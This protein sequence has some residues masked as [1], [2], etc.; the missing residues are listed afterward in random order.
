MKSACWDVA[1][2]S[3]PFATL[4]YELPDCFPTSFWHAGLVVVVP[5]GK[6]Y[7]IGVLLGPSRVE[8]SG[9]RVR[10]VLWPACSRDCL[11]EKYMALLQDLAL[12]QSQLP[13]RVLANVLPRFLKDAKPVFLDRHAGTQLTISALAHL[14]ASARKGLADKW[15]AGTMIRKYAA[16]RAEKYCYVVQ[17]PPWPIRPNAMRQW[18]ILHYL[19]ENRGASWSQVRKHVPG[20]STKIL[21]SLAAKGLVGV[22]SAPYEPEPPPPRACTDAFPLSSEQQQGLETLTRL[23]HKPAPATCLVHGVTG[24]GKTRVYLEL[25]R[26]CLE[27]GQ[28]VL[29]LAPEVAIALQLFAEAKGFFPDGEVLLYHGYQAAQTREATFARMAE[30]AAPLLVVGTRSALFLPGPDPGLIILDEEHD[31]SFKQD[32]RLVYHAKEVGYYRVQRSNGL[33][34][35]GSATPDMKTFYAAREEDIG[36]VSMTSRIGRTTLPEI[37]LVDL[38][39]FPAHAGPFAAPCLE[40]LNKALAAGDQIIIMHNRRGY[41]PVLYCEDCGEPAQCSHCKISLTYHKDVNRMVCHYCGFTRPFPMICDHCGG[42]IF[43]PV[44]AGTEK[45]EE[46]LIKSLPQ[47][48]GIARLDRD[49]S[50]RQGQMEQILEAF[51]KGQQQVLVGTQM[52]SKGHHFPGVTLVVV[53]DGDLGLNLPDYRA[54]ERTFQLLVQVAGRAGRGEKPGKVLIQTRNPEHHCWGFIKNNDYTGFFDQEIQLRKRFGYPPF[55]KLGLLRVSYPLEWKEG[56]DRLQEVSEVIRN[57]ASRLGLRVLGPAP[58]PL[59][60]L[61]GRL[62]FQCLIKAANWP[63]IRQ[64]FA[65]VDHHFGRD[66]HLRFTYDLDPLNML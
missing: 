56:S 19:W 28:R 22:R 20:V 17:D 11:D 53:V 59:Q 9:F 4:T 23:L 8:P 44:G 45:L 7:R 43:Q 14:D 65:A 5:M 54:T 2:I 10:T 6:G 15:L 39:A 31:G 55:V 36:V 24:S 35:L 30:D 25:A 52:L 3:A 33:L 48:T 66:R 37:R 21:E 51:A 42:S 34:V 13:G 50:R 29:L 40:E 58:A 38:K 18:D 46:F 47:G 41:A 26:V 63:A 57:Q 27:R 1:I 61:R 62:R 64:L 49:S 60:V 32:E 16:P 12:R